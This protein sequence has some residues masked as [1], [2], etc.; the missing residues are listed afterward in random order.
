MFADWVLEWINHKEPQ[1]AKT[2]L[3]AYRS[4]ANNRIIPYFKNAHIVLQKLTGIDIQR[5]YDQLLTDGL[6]PVSL[7][8][9]HAVV[10]GSLEYAYK[11]GI[12]PENPAKRV[13]L[14]HMTRSTVGT[15][16]TW[17]EVQKMLDALHD[18]KIFPAVFLTLFYGLR[19]EEV[20]GLTWSAI[21]LDENT[22]RI[23]KTVTRVGTLSIAN[24]TKNK[25]SNNVQ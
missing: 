12:I 11:L 23:Q 15:A 5:F 1:L 13:D 3:E 25:S 19:R 24:T 20:L 4:Y 18:S 2:T 16:Y 14:P 6:S 7:R 9:Y 22:I 10:N 21:N 17:E 8:R